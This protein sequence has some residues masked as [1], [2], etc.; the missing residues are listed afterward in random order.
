MEYNFSMNQLFQA[1]GTEKLDFKDKENTLFANGKFFQY[2]KCADSSGY[3]VNIFRSK[4]YADAQL[5]M[6]DANADFRHVVRYCH[7]MYEYKSRSYVV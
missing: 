1:D 3:Y 6:S 2:D 4:Q 7:E 5:S